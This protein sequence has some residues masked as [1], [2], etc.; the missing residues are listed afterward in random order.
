VEYT[1]LPIANHKR[2]ITSFD[3]HSEYACIRTFPSTNF[4]LQLKENY[5]S[6]CK[7]V[8]SANNMN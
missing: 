1:V 4:D 5:D 6:G 7:V 8:C 2:H 3:Y